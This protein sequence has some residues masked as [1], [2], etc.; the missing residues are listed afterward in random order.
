MLLLISLF[1][2]LQLEPSHALS[3]CS[4][5]PPKAGDIFLHR[6]GKVVEVV[7]LADLMRNIG[8]NLL[9]GADEGS[10]FVANDPENRDT[11]FFDL[12]EKRGDGLRT[13][14]L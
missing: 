4:H 9:S 10:L 5:S 3:R 14:Y 12:F 11:E 8:K 1:Y 13:S 7:V 6:L 2:D